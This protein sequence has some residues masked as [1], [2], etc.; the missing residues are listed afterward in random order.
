MND[1][2]IHIC[3]MKVAIHFKLFHNRSKELYL[4]HE[5]ID[6][7]SVAP[8]IIPGTHTRPTMWAIHFKCSILFPRTPTCLT[9]LAIHINIMY[10]RSMDPYSFQ[11]H[12]GQP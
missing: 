3:P 4:L 1:P 7:L 11:E 12:S 9:T 10:G 8:L 5:L 2:G 6:P